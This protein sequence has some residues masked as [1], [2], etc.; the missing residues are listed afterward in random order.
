MLA[1]GKVIMTRAPAVKFFDT[2][3]PTQLVEQNG[4]S[5]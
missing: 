3:N 4:R 2:T 5:S 1:V